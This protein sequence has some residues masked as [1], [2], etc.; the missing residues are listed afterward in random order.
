M[1]RSRIPRSL[2]A[3]AALALVTGTAVSAQRDSGSENDD[4]TSPEIQINWLLPA[5]PVRVYAPMVQIEL[6]GIHV[7]TS[8][9][10]E[11][12]LIEDA[13][14]LQSRRVS[15]PVRDTLIA[16]YQLRMSVAFA[17]KLPDQMTHSGM[18]VAVV[19]A[20]PPRGRCLTGTSAPLFFHPDEGGFLVYDERALC[21]Y[22]RCGDLRG[23][24]AQ[25]RGTWRVMGG[26]P[27]HAVTSREEPA[28]EPE[29][30]V[31]GGDL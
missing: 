8:M 2:A 15:E 1:I 7:S 14:T 12:R 26:G 20:C 13:G 22:F 27:L 11:V 25:Q 9:D 28:D 31:D 10:V 3:L 18:V 24:A 4:D 5:S 19:R 6:L 23:T 30:V 29:T 17:E 21:A 16:P